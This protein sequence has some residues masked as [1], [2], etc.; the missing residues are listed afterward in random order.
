MAVTVDKVG[1]GSTT[2][3]TSYGDFRLT[4]SASVLGYRG[5]KAAS[6]AKRAQ[7]AEDASLPESHV[8]RGGYLHVAKT[9]RTGDRVV[10]VRTFG[11]SASE[12]RMD[13]MPRAERPKPQLSRPTAPAPAAQVSAKAFAMHMEHLE[14]LRQV[15][16]GESPSISTDTARIASA[17]WRL[18]W[19]A[20]VYKIPVPAAG[21]GPDGEMFYAWNAGR[22]HLELEIIPGQSA[23]FFYRDRE[24]GEFWGEDYEV[25]APLPARI[26]SKLGLFQ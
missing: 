19:K 18:I 26:V 12:G 23:E 13:A 25:G 8:T 14:F 2:G 15:S 1:H 3:Y 22:Y 17:A 16:T 11:R 21:T 4:H 24:T 9:V 20:S 10:L 7:K 5:Y 6:P